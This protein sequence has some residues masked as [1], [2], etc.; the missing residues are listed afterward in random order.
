MHVFAT[1]AVVIVSYFVNFKF[2]MEVPVSDISSI[3]FRSKLC[4]LEGQPL[5]YDVNDASNNNDDND[6]TSTSPVRDVAKKSPKH[7]SHLLHLFRIVLL[8]YHSVA[9]SKVLKTTGVSRFEEPDLC[10]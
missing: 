2:K 7:F 6:D 8:V 5:W 10:D 9:W 4:G 1:F 3:L